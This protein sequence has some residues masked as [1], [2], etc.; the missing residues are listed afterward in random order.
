MKKKKYLKPDIREESYILTVRAWVT[1][2]TTS[3]A[4]QNATST[5]VASQAILN[6]VSSTSVAAQT[7]V[8]SSNVALQNAFARAT[9][10]IT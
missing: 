10:R 5:S 4:L 2:T 7:R 6:R 8:V 1:A 3:V 9:A